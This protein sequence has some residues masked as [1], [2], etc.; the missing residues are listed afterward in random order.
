MI[1]TIKKQGEIKEIGM[2]GYISLSHL[3]F[4][5]DVMLFGLVWE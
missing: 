4:V 3:L 5:D 1:T 2:E